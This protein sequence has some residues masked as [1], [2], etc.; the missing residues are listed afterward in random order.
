MLFVTSKPTFKAIFTIIYTALFGYIMYLLIHSVK[1]GLFFTETTGKDVILLS[2]AMMGGPILLSMI[3]SI[4]RKRYIWLLS[5]PNL[6]L[7][8]IIG[9][10]MG[11]E[12]THA[13]IGVYAAMIIV[14]YILC[15]KMIIG[16][17]KEYKS[18]YQPVSVGSSSHRDYPTGSNGSLSF[19]E[20]EAY[21]LHN[22]HS[23]Y[24]TSA[25]DKI[26]NDPNLTASQ[27]AELKNH[28]F[29]YGD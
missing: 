7:W 6:F 28:L 27:K 29:Y 18:E 1:T 23:A 26:E 21:I 16:E 9:A 13:H 5:I 10:A 17:K 20:K 4:I 3:C 2:A 14:P 15:L 24:S 11:E 19:S 12:T 8:S 22:C 25:M